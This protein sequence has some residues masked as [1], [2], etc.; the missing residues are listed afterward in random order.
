[1]VGQNFFPPSF[2]GAVVGVRDAGCGIWD[3]GSVMNKNQDPGSGI[4]KTSRI[5]N[6]V[7]FLVI[8]FHTGS[9]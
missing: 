9:S 8:S 4:K 1:M 2:L 7:I 5:R 3:L 6:T